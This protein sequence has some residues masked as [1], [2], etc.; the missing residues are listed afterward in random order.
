MVHGKPRPLFISLINP[1]LSYDILD[2]I[3]RDLCLVII[4]SDYIVSFI[5]CFY[6]VKSILRNAR[7]AHNNIT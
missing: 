5:Q 1:P 2:A 3:Y 6:I 7:M 4:A